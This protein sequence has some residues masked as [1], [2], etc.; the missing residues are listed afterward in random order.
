[1]TRSGTQFPST[2]SMIVKGFRCY[3]N[4]N[5]SRSWKLRVDGSDGRSVNGRHGKG[6]GLWSRGLWSRGLWSRGR[7]GLQ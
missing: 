5:P 1:M 2:I 3:S 7:C 4:E 6:R